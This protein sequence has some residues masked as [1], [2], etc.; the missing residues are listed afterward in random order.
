MIDNLV[1]FLRDLRS[2]ARSLIRA[3]GL[4]LTVIAT[5]AL[6]QVWKK[7]LPSSKRCKVACPTVPANSVEEDAVP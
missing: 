2:A 1:T 4:A 7:F 3:Q 6:D 5:L